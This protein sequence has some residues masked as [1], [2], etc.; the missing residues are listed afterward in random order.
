[1]SN[2]FK[3]AKAKGATASAAPSK[4]EV[5]VND[6]TFHANLSRLAEVN[7]Q[8]D[9]LSAESKVLSDEVK[10]RSIKEFV[11]LYES[12]GKYPGSFNIIGTGMSGQP[13]ASLMFIPTDKYIKITEDRYNELAET[14]GQEL[15]VEKTT[16][17][18]DAELIEQYGDL[19]SDAISK[20]KGIPDSA[21]AKLIKAVVSYEIAK[22]TIQE[23]PKYPATI[24]EMIEEIKPVFQQKNVKVG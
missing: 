11:S 1:M 15:V 8:I 6:P 21:K 7:S 17:V 16:Y 14:Y 13:D 19:L 2:L 23:L 12:T 4:T 18:M 10:Q 9:E 5:V 22:G 20:I 3:A 24:T